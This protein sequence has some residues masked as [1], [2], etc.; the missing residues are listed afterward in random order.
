MVDMSARVLLS[1]D[2]SSKALTLSSADRFA[3]CLLAAVRRVAAA[4]IADA[5]SLS[6]DAPDTDLETFCTCWSELEL[7]DSFLEILTTARAVARQTI[8][9]D[10]RTVAIPCFVLV[11]ATNLLG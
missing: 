9:R 2:E 3:E 4:A 7:P 6:D 1:A 5:L 10:I 11:Y 8:T